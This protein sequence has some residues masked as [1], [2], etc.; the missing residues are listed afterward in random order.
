MNLN[1]RSKDE[2]NQSQKTYNGKNIKYHKEAAHSTEERIAAHMTPAFWR[3][4]LILRP[5][6][7]AVSM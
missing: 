5:P 6:W 3:P 2:A 4:F 1:K 7:W